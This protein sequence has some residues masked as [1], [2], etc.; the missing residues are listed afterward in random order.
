MYVDDII[1][2]GSSASLIKDIVTQ[3]NVAFSLKFL[4]D[5][6]YFLRIEVKKAAHGSL[7]LTQSKYTRDLL[8]RTNMLESSPVK[9]PMQS[10]CKLT[11]TG[12]AALTDPFFYRSVV[13]ALQYATITRPE[14]VYAVNKVCHFMAHPL[15][16]HWVAIKRI[17][18]YLK[19]TV[20][21]G[22]HVAPLSPSSPPSLQLFCDTDWASDPGDRRSTSGA[23]IF[24]GNNLIAWW[25]KKH[26]VV[27]PSST[28]AE[29]RSLA[30]A[31]AD[32]LWIKTLR[33]CTLLQNLQL[34]FVTIS[35]L[36]C[37]LIIL[38]C[39]PGQNT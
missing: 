2:T 32:L 8:Q 24:F 29:Y 36:S 7:L 25:S 16:T 10:T 23:A 18:R 3:F 6:D 13:G 9:T 38:L 15:E 35:L 34:C 19:G 28:E 17:V 4:G 30:Q 14:L 20:G 26:P 22:L 31:T 27:A 5:L 11:K 33:N 1:I 12:S 21:H 37:W 39:I